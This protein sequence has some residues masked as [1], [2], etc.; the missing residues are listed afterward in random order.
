MGEK[1][2]FEWWASMRK[3]GVKVAK[4]WSE[5]YYTAFSR[6]GGSQPLTVSYATSPAA[7]VFY[8]KEKLQ[9]APTASLFLPGT[10]FRQSEVAAVLAN[11]ARQEHAK[12]FIDFLLSEPVQRAMQTT[13]WMYPIASS[14]PR[15]AVL[16]HAI[17]P[18]RYA[19][20]PAQEIATN[21]KDWIQRWTQVVLK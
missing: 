3:N 8:S 18:Q 16:E 2:A 17:E 21:G 11:T 20:L 10:V 19:E 13:M 4:G 7:E 15:A 6:N 14:T 12:A 1:A 5:A 9:V